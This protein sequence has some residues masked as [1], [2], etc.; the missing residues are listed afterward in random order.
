MNAK[1]ILYVIII[2]LFSSITFNVMAQDIDVEKLTKAKK[3]NWSGS[4]GANA[5][6]YGVNGI[7]NRSNPFYWSLNG[8]TNF[9]ILE[10]FNIPF[11]FT[12][13]KYQSSFTKPF[14][15]LGISPKYKWATLHLGA[16][17]LTFNSYTLAGHVFNGAGIELTPKK[18]RFA[19]MYG[20]LREAI[21]LDTT[22]GGFKIPSFK[23]IGYGAKIGY[24]TN[25]NFIDVIL[26]AAK[27]NVN[28]I[29]GWKDST[30]A[31]QLLNKDLMPA[32]NLVFGI[33]AQQLLFKKL[34]LSIE[35]GL[36]LYNNTPLDS[37]V[38]KNPSTYKKNIN[39]AGKIS[40]AYNL[41]KFNIRGDYERILPDYITM[42]SYFINNDL[43]NITI[44]PSG[45]LK[46]GKIV[47]NTSF[48]IQKNN[49]TG[50]KTETTKRFISSANISYNPN[51]NWGVDAN[52]NNFFINQLPST[53]PLN[54]SV[55]IKQLNQTFSITPRYTVIADTTALHNFSLSANYQNV[56]DRNV[57]TKAFG[58]MNSWVMNANHI[59][60]FTQKNVSINTG[61]NYNNIKTSQF[62][63]EQYGITA[64]YNRS[65][66]EN[67]V[68]VNTNINYNLSKI[69]GNSDG[70]IININ[71]SASYQLKSK[72]SFN[73]SLNICKT[74]SKAFNNF[75]EASGSLSYVYII[76]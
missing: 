29:E 64:G 36:S 53:L 11:S 33:S 60:T 73:L 7:D 75:T 1:S 35:T 55:R 40:L 45:I 59:S 46:E 65:F 3:F 49:L 47:F 26:F 44:S 20:R 43:E 56:N 34:Q 62:V 76:K 38:N 15:Q 50:K 18:W 9:T 52:Y 69:D 17:S 32:K 61:I 51:P 6:F 31:E 39:W 22:T 21:E 74:T 13:G 5:N 37:S 12:V 23:R 58:N 28:S 42:G 57:L 67:M 72:H 19:A 63:N 16:R 10:T 14:M 41:D 48:G 8:N 66:F 2:C 70:N 54:E 24:G 27:D 4:I 68:N 30:M 25:E 71:S